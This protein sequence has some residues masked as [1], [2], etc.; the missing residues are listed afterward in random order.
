MSHANG[1]LNTEDSTRL[2]DVLSKVPLPQAKLQPADVIAALAHDKKVLAGKPHWVLLKWP[3]DATITSDVSRET[4]KKVAE[5]I[6]E[7]AAQGVPLADPRRVRVLG[8]NGPN[9]NLL[10]EREPE[11]YGYT[12]YVE[13]ED[14]IY[15]HAREVGA[16][17]LVRQSNHEGELISL[18][19]QARHWADGIVINPAS[20]SH[21][22]VGIRDALS[23][24]TLPAIEVHLT[25]ISRREDF[26]RTSLTAPACAALIS[27]HGTAG[28]LE[29]LEQLTALIERNWNKDHE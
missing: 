16:D 2:D 23:A 22:S 8:L 14:L 13:L 18:I 28:Y 11:T 10:G 25:D 20:Y 1:L 6:C 19:Q 7:M 4:V 21:T 5:W 29:A 27:G 24:V 17:V 15:Q 3:G 9:L 26:R 12:S